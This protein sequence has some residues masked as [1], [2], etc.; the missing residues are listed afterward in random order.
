MEPRAT[1][2][3]VRRR[4]QSP[5]EQLFATLLDPDRL[6][7]VRGV[8]NVTV[9]EEGPAGPL[10]AGTVR[11][12]GLGGGQFL[13]EQ[14]VA[15]SD[16]FR[17][18]Y[19]LRDASFPVDHRFGRIEFHPDG[20]GATARWTSVFTVPGRFGRLLQPAGALGSRVGFTLALAGLDRAARE[21][22]TAAKSGAGR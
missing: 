8:A 10:G 14:L 7:R 9:L 12:V 1:T 21:H 15:L 13:V 16:P 6:A 22:R 3:E 17:F 4:L 19:R 5:P 18:D 2:V 20:E 11:R